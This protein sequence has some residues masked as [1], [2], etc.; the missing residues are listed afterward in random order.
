M[1]KR[2]LALIATIIGSG[3]VVLDG[4][5]VNLALPKIA[6][7]MHTTF[8]DLQWIIDGYLLSLSALILLG[9]SLGDIFGRKKI[10]L[11]G[12]YGFTAVSLLCALAPSIDTLIASRFLQ[13][14][15]GALLVPGGL[16]IINTNF[17][18]E[19]RGRA[20]GLWS[21][22]LAIVIPIGPVVGGYILTITT[23][24]WI[25]LINLPLGLLC[26][27]L[28]IRNVDE[29]K[30]KTDRRLDGVGSLITVIS[31]AAITYGF[32][33][34]PSD[35]WGPKTIISLVVGFGLLPV[36][37]WYERRHP[38]PIVSLSLFKSRNFTGANLMTFA[39]YGALTG[40][41]FILPIYLQTEMGYTAFQAG[42]SLLPV[43]ILMLLLSSRMGALSAEY[44]PRYFLTVGPFLAALAILSLINYGP[45]DNFYTFLIPR[46]LLL[47][48]GL[49]TLAS[50]P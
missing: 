30:A 21:A 33:E 39:M 29:S 6:F 16:A 27:F 12:L 31:L 23:W 44:G 9:G 18:K 15:F 32:I 3:M 8:S 4:F 11:I 48:V 14:I 7:D 34:A 13:G 46:T 35:H 20:I 26:A 50:P 19:E 38:D 45:G 22:W 1:N 2:T 25:F 49:A 41:T 42:L 10:Y 37:I 36:F 24:R 43:S 40:F 5:V 28:A 47:G 17:P